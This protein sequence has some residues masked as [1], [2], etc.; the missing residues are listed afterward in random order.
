MALFTLLTFLLHAF[1]LNS[2]GQHAAT[3]NSGAEIFVPTFVDVG[4]RV[5]VNIYEGLYV[6]RA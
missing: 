3:L 2:S 6:E 4:M 5:K 1:V